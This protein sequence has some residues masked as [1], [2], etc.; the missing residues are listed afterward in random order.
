LYANSIDCAKKIFR[1]EGTRGFFKGFLM[2]FLQG[3]SG[4]FLMLFDRKN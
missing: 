3:F 4:I 2:N 1:I